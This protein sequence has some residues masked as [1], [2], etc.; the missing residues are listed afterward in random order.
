MTATEQPTSS[1]A[2]SP[3]V[4]SAPPGMRLVEDKPNPWGEMF[5]SKKFVALLVGVAFSLLTQVG[6]K[7][8]AEVQEQ[9]I[10]LILVYM[11]AQG[12]ADVGKS[13]A[14]VKT[15]VETAKAHA[16]A[17]PTNPAA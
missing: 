10:N 8:T 6:V 4:F 1:P 16:A 5:R 14:Q 17:R 13:Y 15:K 3:V 2:P 11:G 7:V 9:V 12:V